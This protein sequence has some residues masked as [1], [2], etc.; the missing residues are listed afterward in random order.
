MMPRQF[1][2]SC[3]LVNL[4][5]PSLSFAQEKDSSIPA[6][7]GADSGADSAL[8]PNLE[9]SAEEP[10]YDPVLDAM[11]V[12]AWS[13]YRLSPIDRRFALESASQDNPFAITP[14]RPSYLLPLTYNTSPD[15]GPFRDGGAR[16][17]NDGNVDKMEAKFQLSLKTILWDEIL[18]K[19]LDL[20]FAY[21]QQSYWQ[22]Y[23][24]QASRPFRETVHEPELFLRWLTNKEVFGWRYRL[25]DLGISHQ[26]NGKGEPLSRSW[27]RVF[28]ELGFERDKLVVS[29][30]AWYRLPEDA[31]KDDNPDIHKYLGYGDLRLHYYLE[32]QEFSLMLRNNLDDV[33]NR[34]AVQLEWSFPL[35]K[36][37]RGYV[38]Y[39]NG[40]GESMIDY[41]DSTNRLG[42]GVMLINWM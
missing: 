39:F 5:L 24:S 25:L 20:A 30:R 9:N 14:H 13:D 12:E 26:S 6:D 32:D 33:D 27:N 31:K 7:S 40:Y 38:Q 10:A 3:L 42:V 19:E 34:G 36:K 18:G 21:T 8:L 22:L 29:M 17:L 4:L 28:L 23:N 11:Q 37:I 41:N 16:D 35:Y 15:G 1:L 2:I